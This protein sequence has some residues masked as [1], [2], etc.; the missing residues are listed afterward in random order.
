M[1]N[2]L[3]SVIVPAYNVGEYFEPCIASLTGQTYGNLEIIIVDDGSTDGTPQL[4]DEYAARDSRI[5]VIHKQNGG[6]ASARNAGLD[7]AKGEYIGFLDADDYLDL[8]FYET[9]LDL[10]VRFNADAARSAVVRENSDGTREEWGSEDAEPV[11]VDNSRLL[12]DI[13]EAVGFLPVLLGNKLIKRE[14]VGDIRFDTRFRFAED[15]LF[16]FQVAKNIGTIVYYDRCKHHYRN[17]ESSLTHIAFDETRF[18]EHRVMDEIFRESPEDILPHCIKGD[19]LKSF[20]TIKQM[21]VQGGFDGRYAEM[22]CRIT[23][24]RKAVFSLPIYSRATKLKTAFIWLAPS[25]YKVFIK[26][27]GKKR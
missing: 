19:V 4:C 6:A 7:A 11:A 25:L 18:D 14:C 5:R 13:G 10:I 16:N 23:D 21:L 27:Y 8:D 20:R 26:N 1:S 24:N 17:N 9:L 15:T 12:A 22:R 2:P 3:I